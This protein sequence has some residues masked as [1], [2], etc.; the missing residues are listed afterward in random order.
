MQFNVFVYVYMWMDKVFGVQ[1]LETQ[2]PCPY[3]T[4]RMIEKKETGKEN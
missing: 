4:Y 1:N 3:G 2:S